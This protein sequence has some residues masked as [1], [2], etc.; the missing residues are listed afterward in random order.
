MSCSCAV[1]EYLPTSVECHVFKV[2]L[3]DATYV[4]YYSCTRHVSITNS[5]TCIEFLILT[6]QVVCV[7]CFHKSVVISS[8]VNKAK[9]TRA[10][11]SFIYRD[12]IFG[13]SI[14]TCEHK[15]YINIVPF[16]CPLVMRGNTTA[17]PI[18]YA[19]G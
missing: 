5:C 1:N 3:C 11:S 2:Y 7:I 8:D 13:F 14:K 15:S 17:K 4:K 9:R 19:I 12:T 10:M 18:I 6:C 16:S